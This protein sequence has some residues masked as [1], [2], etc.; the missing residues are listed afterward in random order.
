MGVV[1]VCSECQ[2]MCVALVIVVTFATLFVRIKVHLLL[3]F[4]DKTVLRMYA[5]MLLN[6]RKV[7]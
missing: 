4:L 2:N 5:Y 1:P 7:W 6:R 3:E